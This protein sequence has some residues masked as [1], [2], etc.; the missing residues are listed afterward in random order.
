M[1]Q[2][3]R[4]I[5]FMLVQYPALIW[6]LLQVDLLYHC[7]EDWSVSEAIIPASES[8]MQCRMNEVID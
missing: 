1:V 3:F 2:L 6:G 4:P 5:R 7:Y 8:K